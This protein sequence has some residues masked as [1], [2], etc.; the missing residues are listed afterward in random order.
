MDGAQMQL[1][2]DAMLSVMIRELKILVGKVNEMRKM[3]TSR[4]GYFCYSIK[5]T[6]E[7]VVK[8]GDAGER[9]DEFYH[10]AVKLVRAKSGNPELHVREA[11]GVAH[12]APNGHI[13]AF[14]GYPADWSEAL[15]FALTVAVGWMKKGEA[16]DKAPESVKLNLAAL[17]KS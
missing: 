8:I 14:V 10:S 13:F 5:G 3:E 7:L 4:G 11:M 17:L 15:L 16:I 12:Q 6:P 9:A 1:G 2:G